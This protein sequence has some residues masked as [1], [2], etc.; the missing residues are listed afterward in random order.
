MKRGLLIILMIMRGICVFAD[1]SFHRLG[2]MVNMSYGNKFTTPPHNLSFEVNSEIGM[3]YEF[4][5]RHFVLQ[6][7]GGI[8]YTYENIWNKDISGEWQNMTDSYYDVCNFSWRISDKRDVSHIMNAQVALLL[9]G[10][11]QSWFL[12]TGCKFSY[13]L[14]GETCS[15]ANL[16][17]S[18]TYPNLIVPLT[19]MPNHYYVYKLPLL[20]YSKY[21]QRYSFDVAYSLEIGYAFRNHSGLLSINRS[22]I[23]K[24]SLFADISLLNQVPNLLHALYDFHKKSDYIPDLQLDAVE[25]SPLFQSNAMLSRNLYT[26]SIG[27]KYVC[28]LEWRYNRQC[29]CI[30]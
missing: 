29:H 21:A 13:L 18:G 26:L 6:C 8:Q 28:L 5:R 19:H 14:Y 24:V 11:I 3:V 4:Q 2:G 25:L 1:D 20:K 27:I 16:T 17:T 10:E 15:N 9:G 7:N 30:Y 12:L 22:I 23:H